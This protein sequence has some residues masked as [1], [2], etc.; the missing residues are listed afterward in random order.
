MQIKEIDEGFQDHCGLFGILADS[1][2]ID[3][4]KLTYYGL[5]SLQHRGQESCG[6]AVND[7]G[8]I[9]YHK[10]NGLVHE[11]FNDVV[12]NHLKGFSA[13]GHVRYSTTGSNVRENAQPLVVKYKKGNMALAH[14]GNL[15]NAHIIREKLE[16]E[17]TLFQTSID[18]EVIANLITRNRIKSNNIEEAIL[19]TMDD[20]KGA[21]A[22]LILTPNKLIGI[23]D[24]YG[25]RPLVLG[26]YKG[27]YCLASETCALDTIGAEYI[28]D[29]EPG[30]I[31][32]ITRYGIDSIR[33]PISIKHLCIFE[34]IYFARADSYLDSRCVYDIRKNLGKYLYDESPVDC[35]VVIGVPDSGTT[36]AIGYA[37]EG[38]LRWAEGFIKNRYIGRT[39]INPSQEQR[40]IGV[41]IKLNVLVENV[42]NKKVVLID[43]SIVR[44]TTSRKIIKMLKD[45]GA[46]EVHMRIS[47]P[48]V[49]FPCFYGI[50][51]PCKEQLIASNYSEDEIAKILGA[52][53]LKYL[54][55]DALNKV[56]ENKIKDFCTACFTGRYI[57]EAPIRYNKYVLEDDNN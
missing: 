13:I 26:K 52:E 24:P 57:T 38:K 35:D 16:Q 7:G 21:Y 22:L 2:I 33:Y 46:K 44:G 41:K 4:A 32:T 45:A 48:P 53:S 1:N 23:R 9:F 5:F 15:I 6:I 54:S 30:E 49:I 36:A 18:S 56:V 37:E 8:V 29:I 25:I 31:I 20:I 19:K 40:E 55:I 3:V 11:V 10:D 12:L 51:T 39:F 43:D 28:R 17:G 47:S 27:C 50:D 34:Y 42:R 14:N